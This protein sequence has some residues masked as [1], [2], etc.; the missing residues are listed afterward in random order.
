[1]EFKPA[2]CPA[3]GGQLQIPDDRETVKCMYCGCDIVVR[4]VLHIQAHANVGNLMTLAATA[5]EGGNVDEAY[6]YYTQVLEYEGSNSAAWFGKAEAAG[7]SSSLAQPRIAEM[8][9]CFESAIQYSSTEER[10][11]VA[12]NAADSIH[13]VCSVLY[14]VSLEGENKQ[15]AIEIDAMRSGVKVSTSDVYAERF[16]QRE[17]LLEGL[18]RAHTYSPQD[19]SI[20]QDIIG[21]CTHDIVFWAFVGRRSDAGAY[22]K[23]LSQSKKAFLQ[24]IRD[25]Y[26]A[27]MRALNPQYEAEPV[28]TSSGPCFVATAAAGDPFHP[29]VIILRRYRDE[30]LRRTAFGRLF[31]RCY[32]LIGPHLAQLLATCNPLRAGVYYGIVAPAALV[33]GR[34]CQSNPGGNNSKVDQLGLGRKAFKP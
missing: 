30:R 10:A 33:A 16:V 18:R 4:D 12:K 19:Q 34:L 28:K 32:E 26:I 24:Q 2:T 29:S 8:V 15:L 17:V 22:V 20:I 1:M 13:Q 14:V 7:W 31:I 27:R 21:H 11:N 6:K 5:Q 25:E 3:C 9:T 23:S